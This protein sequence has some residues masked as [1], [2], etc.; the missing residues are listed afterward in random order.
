MK[1]L[2]FETHVPTIE[3]KLGSPLLKIELFHHALPFIYTL[4]LSDKPGLLGFVL[5]FVKEKK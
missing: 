5:A 2:H 1:R 4:L 3:N